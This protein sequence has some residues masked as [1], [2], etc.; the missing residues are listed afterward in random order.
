MTATPR[1]APADVQASFC[2][3]LVDEW[4]RGGVT[5]A[6]VSP[7]SRSTPLALA[8]ADDPR[9]ALRVVLDER[10]A[11][12][13]ALGIARATGAPTL[14]LC[15][16]GTAA[17]ELHAAVAEAH[18]DRVP[19]IVATADRPAELHGIGAPQTVD[20]QHLFGR[21]VRWFADPGVPSEANRHAWRSLAARAVAEATAGGHGPGPVHLNLAFREPLVGT[22]LDV[23]D[24]RAHG[25]PWHRA[26]RAGAPDDM[27]VSAA[28]E[29]LAGRQGVIVVGADGGDPDAVH[30]LAAALGWPV[31]ADP[32]SGARTGAPTTV[33]TIDLLLRDGAIADRLLP[34]VVLRLGAPWAS[35]VLGQWL[36]RVGDDMLVDPWGAWLD[37]HRTAGEVLACDPSMLCRAVAARSPERAPM[38]WTERWQRVESAA[39][40]A[41]ASVLDTHEATRGAPTEPVIARSLLAGLPDGSALV[42]SSSMPI[43]DVEWFGGAR[44]GVTVHANR[45]ANGIDGV[46]STVL[47]V[48]TGHRGGPVVGLLGD[49]AFLHDAGALVAAASRAYD[50]TFVLVDNAGGGIFEFLPQASQLAR[51]RFELLFGT[52]QH[53][54]LAALV[55]AHGLHLAEVHSAHDL[56]A[57]VLADSGRPGVGVVLVRTD[58]RDNVPQH[59]RVYAAVRDAVHTAF[60]PR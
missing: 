37:P 16:S 46:V 52:P 5:H 35:K 24:G 27:L 20:Q 56:V 51:D 32:R 7:G 13:V 45:G 8:I 31:L 55:R 30:E 36:A 23:P 28:I 53:V 43:R 59:D 18:L 57:A 19:L 15:T 49:L 2:A 1:P 12:F 11:S 9:L 41:V 44:S 10:S 26:R 34:D 14:V 6:V 50:A 25:A 39:A 40:H 48:A 33:S 4:V 21:S 22:P 3:T 58:R 42:V 47:G 60:A 38:A 54:D 29:R 17:V